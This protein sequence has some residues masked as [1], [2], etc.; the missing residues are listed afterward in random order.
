MRIRLSL[1]L[2]LLLL[3]GICFGTARPAAAAPAERD[4]AELVEATPEGGTLQLEPGHYRG[5]VTIDK[6]ITIEGRPGVVIDGH[7]KGSVLVVTAPDVTLRRVELRGSGTSLMHEDSAAR[8]KAPRFRIEDSHLVDVLFGVYMRES[9]DSHVLRNTVD[10]KDV[11]FTMRGDGIHVYQSPRSVVQGNRLHSGRDVIAFFSNGTQVLD[12]VVEDGRYGLHV[13]YSDDVLVR[14]N[15]MLRNSTS[16]YIMYSKGTVVLDNVLALSDGPSGY[17]MTAKESDVLEVKRN[18]FVGDRVGVFLD[19]SPF[20]AAIT[21]RFERNIFAYNIVGVLLQPAVRNT[22]FTENSFI[23]NQEQVSTTTGGTMRDNKWT[24]DGVGNH[25]SDYAGYDRAGD[26]KGDVPYRAEGLFD[27][28]TDRHPQLTFFAETPSARAL[29]AAAR[30]F[31][32]LRPEPKAVDDAPLIKPLPLP[33]LK[34]VTIGSSRT[35]LLFIS[36]A[37]LVVAALL[38]RR[39]SRPLV[40]V[41]P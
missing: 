30:A 13:M 19:S 24:I 41:T 3:V 4:L 26:G 16:L 38:V 14:G 22:E 27:A 5:G 28:L 29:D 20:S 7:G 36:L 23:D 11:V 9:P 25:W 21:T 18:R 17:G 32:T 34:G 2:P 10:S 33:A 15:R 37:M 12:N 1:S 35:E 40:R 31:P 8:V 6:P 39:G